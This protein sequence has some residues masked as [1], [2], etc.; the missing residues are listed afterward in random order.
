LNVEAEILARTLAIKH[1]RKIRFNQLIFAFNR[2][3]ELL[4]LDATQIGKKDRIG[5]S[6][7]TDP[8]FFNF[9]P[10]LLGKPV[11]NSWLIQAESKYIETIRIRIHPSMK[12]I[13]LKKN[14]SPSS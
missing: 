10:A 13:P 11:S 9:A 3:S 14:S 7:K 2:C 12:I 5:N 1:M 8:R 6:L 4:I